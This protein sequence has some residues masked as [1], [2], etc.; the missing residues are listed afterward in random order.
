MQ[1]TCP[2]LD[3]ACDAWEFVE[4]SIVMLGM[5]EFEGLRAARELY[6]LSQ[7]G[8]CLECSIGYFVFSF[9]H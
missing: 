6:T 2:S 3:G 9:I 8:G 7:G 5:R 1:S 4:E